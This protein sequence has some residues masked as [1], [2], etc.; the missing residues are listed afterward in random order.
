[1]FP[2]ASGYL[3]VE[4]DGFLGRPVPEDFKCLL[5]QSGGIHWP[6]RDLDLARLE[7]GQGQEIF[8]QPAE[9]FGVALDD[10]EKLSAL[11]G[12]RRAANG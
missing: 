5:H 1:M 9:P 12:Y 7:I 10:F 2:H 4:F 11:L 8:G 3:V 6:R